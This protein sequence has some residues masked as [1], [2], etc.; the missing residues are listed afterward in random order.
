MVE[1]HMRDFLHIGN[2]SSKQWRGE[3]DKLRSYDR[4]S[5][6]ALMFFKL[7]KVGS[8]DKSGTICLWDPKSG[9]Q[10]GR[11]LAGHKQFI[12]ALAWEPLHLDGESILILMLTMPRQHAKCQNAN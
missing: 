6:K 2:T 3:D 12:T 9:K 7:F 5:F 8:G 11:T 10:V 1:E 4:F